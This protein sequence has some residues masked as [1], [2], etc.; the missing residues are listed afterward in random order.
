MGFFNKQFFAGM[1]AGIALTFVI[2]IAAVFVGSYFFV[3][4]MPEGIL[5]STPQPP[6]FPAGIGQVSLG[7]VDSTWTFEGIDGTAVRMSQLRGRV[8]FL[9][10]WAT[11]CKPC[12]EEL[13]SIQNLHDQIAGLGVEFVLLS[14]ESR[15]KVQSYLRDNDVGVPCYVSD[16]GIPTLLKSSALPTTFIIDTQGRVVF[17]HVG[18]ARWDSQE[19]RSFIESLL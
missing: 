11:W 1:A 18:L 10:M 19:C 8:V 9:N 6:E 14:Q 16:G 5:S 7:S 17:R 15:E 2:L 12:R 3:K 4:N 13:P